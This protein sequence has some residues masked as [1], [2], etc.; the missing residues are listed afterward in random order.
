MNQSFVPLLRLSL[1]IS[2][3]MVG[4][5]ALFIPFLQGFLFIFVAVLLLNP[6]YAKKLWNKIKRR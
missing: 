3:L 1:G 6:P 5:I 2:L 4:I